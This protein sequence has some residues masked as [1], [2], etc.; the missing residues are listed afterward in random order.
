MSDEESKPLY[1][2][3]DSDVLSS[4][5]FRVRTSYLLRRLVD[6]RHKSPEN[7]AFDVV[8][9][10]VDFHRNVGD[11][12][13]PLRRH[14]GAGKEQTERQRYIS[15]FFRPSSCTRSSTPRHVGLGFWLD[16]K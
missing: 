2:S 3:P 16:T 11:I 9:V 7:D 10:I 6:W 14:L 12:V 1:S 15:D 5:A 13:T 8:K 4:D